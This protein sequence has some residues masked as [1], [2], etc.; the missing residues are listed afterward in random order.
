VSHAHPYSEGRANDLNFEMLDFLNNFNNP[1]CY[2]QR[3]TP[4]RCYVCGYAQGSC[5]A[6]VTL[7]APG[8][9]R[10]TLAV[11]NTPEQAERS[12][13]K[14][15]VLSGRPLAAALLAWSLLTVIFRALFTKQ[16]PGLQVFHENY[17]TD[18]LEPI[19]ASERE[20][21]G[22]FSRCIACGRCDI[23]EGQRI[24][25]S[26]GEYPGLMQLVL[27]S[28][29][30]M[31]DFDAAARGFAHVPSDVLRS[32]VRR[33]P[34]RIPFAELAAFVQAKAPRVDS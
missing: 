19:D 32:K 2:G 9:T 25:A 29:R 20:A 10:Y 18:G 23:G 8:V 31:P 21:L 7:P 11:A 3:N 15:G 30:S 1:D 34:V 14:V 26:D 33:C 17:G 22:R 28:T 27:G 6:P 24:A 13:A 12:L 5:Y 4:Y 16:P